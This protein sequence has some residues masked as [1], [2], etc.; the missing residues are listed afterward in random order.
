PVAT[1]DENGVAY[2]NIKRSTTSSTEIVTISAGFG[3]SQFYYTVTNAEEGEVD[4]SNIY[5]PEQ[6]GSWFNGDPGDCIMLE[7]SIE[8]ATDGNVTG[9]V[10]TE[11]GDVPIEGARVY[12]SLGQSVITNADGEFSLPVP[13]NTNIEISVRG[14]DSQTVQANESIPDIVLEL[15]VANTA[16]YVKELYVDHASL[17]YEN[18]EVVELFVDA[19]DIDGDALTYSWTTSIGSL[20][21]TTGTSLEWTAPGAG[22]GTATVQVTISD[23]DKTSVESILLPYGATGSDT[24]GGTNILKAYIV[25]GSRPTVPVSSVYVILHTE[26]G[27]GVESYLVT[28]ADGIADFGDVGRALVTVTVAYEYESITESET[29]SSKFTSKQITTYKD[30]VPAEFTW[31][32][33][34]GADTICST[35]TNI[36]VEITGAPEQYDYIFLPG[37]SNM[38]NGITSASFDICDEDLNEDG[39]LDLHALAFQYEEN[40]NGIL[41]EYGTL[42]IADVLITNTYTIDLNKQPGELEW[43]SNKLISQFNLVDDYVYSYIDFPNTTEGS[44]LWASDLTSDS[45]KSIH[46]SFGDWEDEG[47][48]LL[49]AGVRSIDIPATIGFTFPDIEIT[50]LAYNEDSS[51]VTW[52]TSGDVEASDMYFLLSKYT[53]DT[54][55]EVTPILGTTDY[56]YWSLMSS[57]D[58]N[59]HTLPELPEVISDWLTEDYDNENLQLNINYIAQDEDFSEFISAIMQGDDPDA[60]GWMTAVRQLTISNQEVDSVSTIK[61]G[62]V[63]KDKPQTFRPSLPLSERPGIRELIRH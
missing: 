56:L 60:F 43:S 29:Y 24:G 16:P 2:V 58:T 52:E 11:N 8:I 37:Y 31:Y 36:T 20:S 21:T 17:A 45:S 7:N 50:E 54:N 44:L 19:I 33:S 53:S 25:D 13:L 15:I 23:G 6:Q 30:I 46:A 5:S 42:S 14:A 22:A 57:A 18:S 48:T 63:A 1:T 10:I 59:T 3:T 62:K 39:S 28:G 9:T 51:T 47:S 27:I 61:E 12:S 40:D 35:I 4:T 55:Y 32:A 49:Q 26:D 41:I 34:A 38:S